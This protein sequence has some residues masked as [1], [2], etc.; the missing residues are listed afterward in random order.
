MIFLLNI[1]IQLMGYWL[2]PGG[3]R[4]IARS[5]LIIVIL[6]IAV[7]NLGPVLPANGISDNRMLN[8]LFGG[9]T[10]GIGVGLIYRAGRH[11]GRHLDPRAHLAAPL[12]LS[13]EH[14][15]P[16]HRHADHL[17]SR[18]GLRLEGALY[19]A[20]ALFTTGL[21]TDYVLEGP[22]VIRTAMIITDNPAEVSQRVFDNLQR[23]ATSWRIKGEYTGV[24]RTMLYVTVSRSQVRDLKDEISQADPNAFVVIGMGHAAYG[25]GFRRVRK[26]RP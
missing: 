19:A 12:R 11:H 20:I 8:A 14:N 1:P 2:L 17:G 26:P 24:E 22:S 25:A 10:S 3:A 16:L 4:V 7:D 5:V 18:G 23:G 6:A 9:I 15:L 21:A 13:Y